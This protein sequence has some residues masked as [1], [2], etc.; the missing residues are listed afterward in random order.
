[1]VIVTLELT[2][3]EEMDQP[4]KLPLKK[5]SQKIK[6]FLKKKKKKKNQAKNKG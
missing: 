4:Q 5:T 1:M 2:N 3:T 6:L